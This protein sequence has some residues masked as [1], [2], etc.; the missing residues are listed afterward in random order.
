MSEELEDGIS[1]AELFA[2]VWKR[3]IFIAIITFASMVVLTLAVM[4][5]VNPGRTTYQTTFELDYFNLSENKYP[6]GKIFDYRDIVS[7]ENVLSVIKTNDNFKN[8]DVENFGN[9]TLNIVEITPTKTTDEVV[10]L[11][12]YTITIKANLF[13]NKE[14]AS[15][16]ISKLIELEYNKVI[17]DFNSIVHDVSLESAL[18]SETFELELSL[19]N[20]QRSY[21]NSQYNTLIETYGD[22]SVNGIKLSKYQSDISS[23]F[24]I[25]SIANLTTKLTYSNFVKDAEKNLFSLELKKNSLVVQIDENTSKINALTL[26]RDEL[27]NKA[28]G[29]YF[30]EIA[31]YNTQIVSLTTTNIELEIELSNV[32]SK[33]YTCVN[34]FTTEEEK[35]EYEQF[36]V[37][38]ETISN[39]LDIFTKELTFVSQELFNEFTLAR[40]PSRDIVSSAGSISIVLAALVGAVMGGGVSCVVFIAV[41]LTNKEKEEK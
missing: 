7:D 37:E 8:I 5:V 36:V 25:N 14:D 29:E 19:L 12:E 18:S 21:I 17:T 28:N 22:Q 34:D 11:K 26:Q 40:I 27:L 24:T 9:D 16:F 4:L 33:I 15:E 6:S 41:D 20:T 2:I 35:K 23:Y 38:I 31:A 1:I 39:Q 32:E 10:T 30:P 13:D 3:K